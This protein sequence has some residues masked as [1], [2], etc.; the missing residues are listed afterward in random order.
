[1]VLIPSIYYTRSPNTEQKRDREHQ[2]KSLVIVAIIATVLLWASAFPAIRVALEAYTPAEVALLRYIV[3][4]AVLIVYALIKRIPL[5]RW[6][7]LPLIV[8]C[9]FIGFTVY[10]FM[11]NAGQM[12]VSAGIA[13]FIISS[14]VGIIALLA[15]LFFGERLGRLG[16]IGVVLCIA[17]V[18]IIAVGKDGTFQLSLGVLRV[19]MATLAI[20]VYSII[21]KPLLVRYSPI[22]FTTYAIWSGT[23]FLFFLAPEAVSSAVRAPIAP[24]LAVI[25]MGL[26]PGV[27]AY[28]AWSYVLSRIPASQAGSYLALIPVVALFL[29]WLWLGEIPTLSALLGGAMVLAGVMLV[30]R[31]RI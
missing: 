8:L 30:N 16:W 17:G 18:G 24:T 29:A 20:S 25:Y 15:W 4:S 27:V 22:H 2:P 5:P 19:F 12:T 6:Q 26:F 31:R 28:I 10:N 13:S 1:M 7:D 9:G 21:Q 11:L 3:A 14:E 23:L